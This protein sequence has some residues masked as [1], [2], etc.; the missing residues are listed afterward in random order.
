[1]DDFFH[2]KSDVN[3]PVNQFISFGKAFAFQRYNCL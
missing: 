3:V 1:M 2:D